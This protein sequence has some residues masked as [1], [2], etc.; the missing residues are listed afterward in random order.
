MEEWALSLNYCISF[1]LHKRLYIFSAT[2]IENY[3]NSWNYISEKVEQILNPELKA[4]MIFEPIY[5]R[6]YKNVIDGF[7][8]IM[9]IDLITLCSRHLN[10]VN[11]QLCPI[12]RTFSELST[13]CVKVRLLTIFFFCFYRMNCHLNI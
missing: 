6:V 2:A 8:E 10:E 3:T 11:Q 7:S 9:H 13:Y 4:T 5:T 12:V 1:V